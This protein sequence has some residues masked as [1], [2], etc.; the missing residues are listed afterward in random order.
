[1]QEKI[2]ESLVVNLEASGCKITRVE[3][4]DPPDERALTVAQLIAQL[5]RL[6]STWRVILAIDD[7]DGGG[8]LLPVTGWEAGSG[9]VWLVS[10]PDE[11]ES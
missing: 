8:S 5:Q 9:E 7:G 11:P 10:E 1:M 3:I 2:V 4:G 6:P